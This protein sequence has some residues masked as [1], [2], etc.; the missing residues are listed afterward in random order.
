MKTLNP[1][2]KPNWLFLY[3]KLVP[4]TSFINAC[5][6]VW[7]DHVEPSLSRIKELE[8][9]NKELELKLSGKTFFDEKE[10]MQ[11]RIDK[12]EAENFKLTELLN[13]NQ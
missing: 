13:G 3:D 12:L 4:N 9:M 2:E 10:V 11:Q 6:A 7:K 5:D 8:S 1:M